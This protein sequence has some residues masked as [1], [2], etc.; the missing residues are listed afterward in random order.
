MFYHKWLTDGRKYPL[1]NLYRNWVYVYL[2]LY[3]K[4]A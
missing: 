3:F 1:G 2:Q 4:I